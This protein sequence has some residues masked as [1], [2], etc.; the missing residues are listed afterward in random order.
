MVIRKRIPPN[1]GQIIPESE[2][3]I[4]KTGFSQKS[5][6]GWYTIFFQKLSK[7][8]LS[9]FSYIHY[10]MVIRKR[11]PPNSGQIIPESEL[12]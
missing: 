8:I 1:S 5:P 4:I 3:D 10:Y 7:N 12:I 2:P 6:R 11:I 9:L